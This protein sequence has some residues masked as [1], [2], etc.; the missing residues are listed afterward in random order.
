MPPKKT[1]AG[2]SPKTN[3]SVAL[4]K[5]SAKPAAR[6]KLGLTSGYVLLVLSSLLTSSALYTLVSPYISNELAAVSRRLDNNYEV[7]ALVAWRM[8]EL[9][10]GWW[11]R[12]DGTETLIYLYSAG[13]R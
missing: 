9:A 5:K 4:T 8:I 1:A 13:R 2:S 11:G 6:G 10:V 7:V 12:F 3:H